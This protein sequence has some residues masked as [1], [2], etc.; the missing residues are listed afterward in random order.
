MHILCQL[1]SYSSTSGPG[2]DRLG[3]LASHL[4]Q[5]KNFYPLMP[6]AEE[7]S[8]DV[9]LLVEH[10]LLPYKPHMLILP[11]ELK[12]FVKVTFSFQSF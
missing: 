1:R 9:G 3:R 12:H 2:V 8:V 7:M 6:P 5:Q 11:S 4:L 10:A